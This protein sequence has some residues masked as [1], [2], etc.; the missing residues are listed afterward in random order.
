[1]EG[2]QRRK[3]AQSFACVGVGFSRK[4]KEITLDV[5]TGQE[6][7]D[8]DGIALENCISRGLLFSILHSLVTKLQSGLRF[9]I[10]SCLLLS[11]FWQF[12][13]KYL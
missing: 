10:S 2:G 7:T 3:R 13:L 8:R 11:C 5:G 6:I 1:M 12:T 4:V 9:D